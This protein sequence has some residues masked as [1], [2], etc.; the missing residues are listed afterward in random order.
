MSKK[1]FIEL[2]K[3]LAENPAH[4]TETAKRLLADFCAAQ[5]PGFDKARF[6]AASGIK[7]SKL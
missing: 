7:P 6:L 5:N 2:A 3:I 4:F 1:H